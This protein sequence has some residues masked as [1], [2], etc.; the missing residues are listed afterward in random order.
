MGKFIACIVLNIKLL[1]KMTPPQVNGRY[2][3]KCF[4]I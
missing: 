1:N 2:G 3:C 4:M